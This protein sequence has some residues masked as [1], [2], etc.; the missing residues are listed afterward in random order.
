MS[1]EQVNGEVDA[2]EPGCDIYALGVILYELL[3]GKLPF[4]G[5]GTA[6]LA[7][8]L[9]REP[10]PP[11]RQRP[12][13]D[14]Q[15]EAI[16]LKAMAKKLSENCPDPLFFPGFRRVECRFRIVSKRIQDSYATMADMAAA[17]ACLLQCEDPSAKP[18][19]VASIIAEPAELRAVEARPGT[20]RDDW[21]MQSFLVRFDDFSD[22]AGRTSL[23]TVIDCLWIAGLI[24]NLTKTSCQA[25]SR[26]TW[27]ASWSRTKVCSVSPSTMTTS[28]FTRRPPLNYVLL[29]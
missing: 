5:L 21:A 12:D 27:A 9:T 24:A 23:V 15:L 4:D 13:L 17:L 19:G 7:Q 20:T 28:S 16:C 26:A 29:P 10:E 18:P 14:R 6:V 1:P 8:I 2:M 11:S 22:L 3:T 25:L